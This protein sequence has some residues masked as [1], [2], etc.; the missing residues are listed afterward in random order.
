MHKTDLIWGGTGGGTAL[1]W[2]RQL[3]TPL[4]TTPRPEVIDEYLSTEIQAGRVLGPTTVPPPS[5][6]INRFGA[7]PQKTK[8][9]SWRLILD[10]SFPAGHSVNDGILKN[11]FP[12]S[13]SLRTDI[14]WNGVCNGVVNVTLIYVP[15][16]VFLTPSLTCSSGF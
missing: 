11:E 6:H 4:T 8:P 16:P 3:A 14:F 10:L 12:V 15:P 13:Y 1:T 9:N 7:I 5:L 2:R